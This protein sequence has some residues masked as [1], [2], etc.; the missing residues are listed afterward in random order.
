MANNLKWDLVFLKI[1]NELGNMSHCV[2]RQVG[3]VAIR[4]GR[5]L[6]SGIN[7]TAVGTCN[8][9]D[10]FTLDFDPIKHR[11]WSDKNE[12]HAEQNLFLFAAKFGVALDGCTIYSSLQPCFHCVKMLGQ[13]GVKRIV[14]SEYYDRVDNSEEIKEELKQRGISY[15]FIDTTR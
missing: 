6:S 13:L 5:I 10:V 14:F 2:S 4:D 1:A 8:C 11:E 7:G 9:D 3:A 15:E 12:I